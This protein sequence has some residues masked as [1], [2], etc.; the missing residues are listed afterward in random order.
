MYK[1]SS[2]QII[3]TPSSLHINGCF[4][5]SARFS[6][7]VN[8]N[9]QCILLVSIWLKLLEHL[10][11][12]NFCYWSFNNNYFRISSRPH[13]Y[14]QSWFF[15]FVLSEK[16]KMKS[17]VYHY[18]GSKRTGRCCGQFSTKS[19]AL[20]SAIYTLV[21]ESET[22]QCQLIKDIS[23]YFLL[24]SFL[25]LTFSQ[26]VSI[27]VVLLYSWQISVN[28]KKYQSLGDVY[29]GET[30]CFTLKIGIY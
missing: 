16:G 6:V 25:L 29:Y 30:I 11:L 14:G 9:I 21:S 2:S 10:T 4:L 20:T 22:A 28:M 5:S 8:F 15:H 3:T 17:T 13:N 19:W 24:N 12:F 7:H 1:K 18:Y 23:K 27:L 26:N